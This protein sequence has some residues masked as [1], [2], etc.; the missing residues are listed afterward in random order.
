[1]KFKRTAALVI[2]VIALGN[3]SAC[4]SAY[5]SD[6]NT[7]RDI[8]DYFDHLKNLVEENAGR[9]DGSSNEYSEEETD[10]GAE[11]D[12]EASLE[13]YEN[14]NASIIDVSSSDD[15]ENLDTEEKADRILDVLETL[16]DEGEVA[17]DSIGY[18]EEAQL[19]YYTYADGTCGGVMLEEFAEGTSGTGTASYETYY[20]ENGK[21]VFPVLPEFNT[22]L[23]PYEEQGLAALIVCNFGDDEDF[24]GFVTLSEKAQEG[25]SEAYL[26]TVL[27]TEDTVSFYRTGLSDYDLICI[28]EHGLIYEDQT[29]IMLQE[30]IDWANYLA[31]EAGMAF[32]YEGTVIVRDLQENRLAMIM[33]EGDNQ[34]HYCLMPEFFSYYYGND[35]LKDTIVWLGC[36]D[37]FRNDTLVEAIAD[38]GAKAVLACTESV[39]TGYNFLMQDA[40]VYMLLYGNT[41]EEALN[42]GKSVWG[43]NDQI[44]RETYEGTEDDTPSEIRYYNGGDEVLVTLTQEALE[45]LQSRE[46]GSEEQEESDNGAVVDGVNL[47]GTWEADYNRMLEIN[48]VSYWYEFGSSYR[49]GNGMSFGADGTFSYWIGFYGGEGT[50]RIEENQIVFWIERYEDGIEETGVLT[51]DSDGNLLMDFGDMAVIDSDGNIT[52]CDYT[53]Y[54]IVW[55]KTALATAP[56]EETLWEILETYTDETVLTFIYD[57]FDGN[58]VYEAF[59]FCGEENEDQIY[60]GVLYFITENGVTALRERDGYWTMGDV[61]YF[62]DSRIVSISEYFTTGSLGYYYRVNGEEVIELA[63][64]GKAGT[65]YEDEKGRISMTD[66]RYDAFI[67][68]TGRTW[69]VYYFYWDNDL[70]EL[71]EYGGTLISENEFL[72]YEGAEDI[73]EAIKGDG[74]RITSIYLRKNGIININGSDGERNV[75]VR[76][77]YENGAVEVYPLENG[78][79]YYEE[80]IIYEAMLPEIATY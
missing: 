39:S 33:P 42:F 56:E 60:I 54:T 75:N 79:G 16:A 6:G 66:S 80:G 4:G 8:V 72:V 47:I 73:L 59:A 27:V 65:L 36:C 17:A 13:N 32:T 19:I 24:D 41:V 21:D 34:F 55:K 69:N 49:Y 58:G 20:W 48:Q 18:D 52:Y 70:K 43:D 71:M 10:T 3:L 30:T 31:K 74:Y 50:W 37:G 2:C 77:K 29:F 64:S 46:T 76:V 11:A 67:D 63:V 26:T 5:F 35:A 23:Y 38:C 45:E 68:G 51:I 7:L 61:I 15:Y 9:I 25:W 1:M 40:F 53:N 22:V 12:M 78:Y 28:Q 62:E 14:V 57:D 44:Y